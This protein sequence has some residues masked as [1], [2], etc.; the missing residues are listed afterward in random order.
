MLKTNLSKVL[1]ASIISLTGLV[2]T[3]TAFAES[4]SESKTFQ[5][6][7]KNKKAKSKMDSSKMGKVESHDAKSSAKMESHD[8]K[9]NKMSTRKPAKVV[10]AKAM[11][12]L[13]TA[14]ETQL[15]TLS[16]IGDKL[17]KNIVKYRTEHGKFKAFDDLKKVDGIGISTIEKLKAEAKL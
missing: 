6:A 3:A 8:D 5:I 13:N 7:K 10:K 9:A 1:I 4:G 14:S 12:N 2:S 15:H 17:A 16:G 11:V